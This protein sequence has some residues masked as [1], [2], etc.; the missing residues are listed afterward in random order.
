MPTSRRT[1]HCI[2][3]DRLTSPH[4]GIDY[5]MIGAPCGTSKFSL[6]QKMNHSKQFGRFSQHESKFGTA[7]RPGCQGESLVCVQRS[8]LIA[9]CY[10]YIGGWIQREER[11]QAVWIQQ[12][13]KLRGSSRKTKQG[14]CQGYRNHASTAGTAACTT[15]D[16]MI[17]ETTS[18]RV[19]MIAGVPLGNRRSRAHSIR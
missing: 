18:S 15:D 3:N 16:I 5:D 6:M 14:A 7:V 11:K 12:R 19:L 1:Q 8:S 9:K 10:C 4:G 2:P 13:M 17:I